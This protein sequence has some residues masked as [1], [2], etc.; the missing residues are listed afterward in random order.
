M[1]QLPVSGFFTSKKVKFYDILP[2][3]EVTWNDESVLQDTT[4]DEFNLK[5]KAEE[6]VVSNNIGWY[7]CDFKDIMVK[8]QRYYW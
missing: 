2:D 6:V 7:L 4:D 1:R 5:E 8:K 3:T